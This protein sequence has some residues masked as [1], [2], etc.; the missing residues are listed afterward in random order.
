MSKVRAKWVSYPNKNISSLFLDVELWNSRK[1]DVY[2]IPLTDEQS[3]L[4]EGLS[5]VHGLMDVN[6]D[7]YELRVEKGE[8]FTWDE[9][10]PRVEFVVAS[11]LGTDLDMRQH[12]TKGNEGTR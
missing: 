7:K 4:V 2:N 9:I 5:G 8:V 3:Q 6:F 10:A 12:I 1:V 11:W